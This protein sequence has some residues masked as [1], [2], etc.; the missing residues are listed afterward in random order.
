MEHAAPSDVCWSH[1]SQLIEFDIEGADL[2]LRTRW[3]TQA[4]PP[5]FAR[6]LIRDLATALSRSS[7]WPLS[8]FA[9]FQTPHV[10]IA[11][12]S[13]DQSGGVA[14]MLLVR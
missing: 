10:A 7:D 12:I 13:V 5:V 11:R 14:M 8:N 6:Q 2:L 1:E 3:P 4:S 9:Y